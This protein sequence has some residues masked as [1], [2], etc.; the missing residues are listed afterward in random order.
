MKGG[1]KY[2]VVQKMVQRLWATAM[3]ILERE[4]ILQTSSHEIPRGRFQERGLQGMVVGEKETHGGEDQGDRGGIE[5][6]GRGKLSSRG[7]NLSPA[8]F[9]RTKSARFYPSIK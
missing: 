5:G 1:D 6:T 7:D 2:E 8:I 3:A 4:G 9:G